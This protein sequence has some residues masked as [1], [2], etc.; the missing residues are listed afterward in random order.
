L[1]G[2]KKIP[3]IGDIRDESAEEIR[4]VIEPKGRS[5]SAEI[6]MEADQTCKRRVL[7]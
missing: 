5:C 4:I 2:D 7:E 3:L 6:I 1:L